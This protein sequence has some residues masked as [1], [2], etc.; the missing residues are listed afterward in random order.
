L[1]TNYQGTAFKPCH[2]RKGRGKDRSDRTTT[3]K[4]KT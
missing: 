3:M 1:V 4:K 2:W